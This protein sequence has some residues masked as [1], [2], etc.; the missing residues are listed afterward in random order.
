MNGKPWN[1]STEIIESEGPITLIISGISLETSAE[2]RIST[3]AKNGTV[4]ELW[5]ALER[6]Y[7]RAQKQHKDWHIY[8]ENFYCV[9]VDT[10]EVFMGS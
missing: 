7:K 9:G 1:L 4:G 6:A 8:I 2:W 5:K 10:Y 3:K